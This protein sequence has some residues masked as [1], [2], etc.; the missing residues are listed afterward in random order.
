[1]QL[2]QSKLV[3]LWFAGLSIS[4]LLLTWYLISALPTVE[5][6][7]VVISI[8]I[9]P[10]K[11]LHALGIPVTKYGWLTLP[12]SIGWLWCVLVW[13]CFYYIAAK[14]LAYLTLHSRGQR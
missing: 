4:H 8:S 7:A 10:W 13:L 6:R 14:V 5:A 2:I 1:M 11:P 12:N 9:A 3:V